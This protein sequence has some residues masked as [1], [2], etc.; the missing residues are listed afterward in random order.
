MLH[1]DLSVFETLP[2]SA[3]IREK[4]IIGPV[5]KSHGKMS[6]APPPHRTGVQKYMAPNGQGGTSPCTHQIAHRYKCVAGW[7]SEKLAGVVE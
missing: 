1:A 7:R 6:V 5:H 4:L 3:L 2:D